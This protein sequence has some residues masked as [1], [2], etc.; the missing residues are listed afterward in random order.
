MYTWLQGSTLGRRHCGT[1]ER[2]DVKINDVKLETSHI[3]GLV[4]MPNVNVASTGVL[5]RFAV[6]IDDRLEAATNLPGSDVWT[7]QGIQWMTTKSTAPKN[8]EPYHTYLFEYSLRT[9]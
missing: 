6:Q 3:N 8:T 7:I 5:S 1:D 2:L 4:K 9:R